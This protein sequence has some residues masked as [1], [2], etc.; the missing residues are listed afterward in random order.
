MCRYPYFRPWSASSATRLSLSSKRGP[1]YSPP[2]RA[3]RWRISFSVSKKLQIGTKWTSHVVP[4]RSRSFRV[5]LEEPKGGIQG[6]RAYSNGAASWSL[7]TRPEHA[8]GL[9]LER[10]ATWYSSLDV[11]LVRVF[12]GRGLG[13]RSCGWTAGWLAGR[14]VL[15][16]NIGKTL[17][18]ASSRTVSWVKSVRETENT[19]R[20]AHVLSCD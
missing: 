4:S 3:F 14:T 15:W 1:L 13:S 8:A 18:A 16:L 17:G 20:V 5:H 9:P 11:T 6:G 2:K 12:V 10:L 19:G 7:S